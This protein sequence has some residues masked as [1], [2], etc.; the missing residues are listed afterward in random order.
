MNA[1]HEASADAALSDI[2]GLAAQG[3]VHVSRRKRS[4]DDAIACLRT[5]IVAPRDR[6][7]CQELLYGTV[8]WCIRLEAELTTYLRRPLRVRDDDLK[9]LLL[10]GL[11]QLRFMTVPPHAAVGATVAACDFLHKPWA[12]ALVNGV[13]RTAL[14]TEFDVGQ[15]DMSV[16]SAH[17]R[18]LIDAFERS[19]PQHLQTLLNANNTAAPMT[20]RVN[21]H[22]TTRACYLAR[23]R[24]ADIA[25]VETTCSPDGV[26]LAQPMPVNQLPGFSDGLVSVQDEAAQLVLGL[27]A[28]RAGE[29]ILDACAAPGGKTTHILEALSGDAEVIALDRAP[30]RVQLIE[31]NLARLGLSCEVRCDDALRPQQWWDGCDFDRILLDAPCSATGVIRRHPDIKLHREAADVNAQVELQSELLTRLWALLKPGGRLV[32]VTCSLL[33]AENDSVIATLQAQQA[34]VRVTSLATAWGV[35]TLHGRQT[36]TGLQDMDGFYFA[37]LQKT[38]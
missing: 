6:A 13:L 29:R 10:L 9:S 23:L 19:W 16:R 4:L 14:R 27:L 31:E 33:P 28:P 11:Y 8:R 1:R 30:K 7:F 12:K 36:I 32:Y 35:K 38:S 3:L 37:V 20:L 34:N 2:R 26:R 18:W 21:R 24:A 25:A 22:A 17:P 5:R 15:T